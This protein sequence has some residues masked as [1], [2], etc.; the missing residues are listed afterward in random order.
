MKT[1]W[2]HLVISDLEKNESFRIDH[3]FKL[4]GEFKHEVQRC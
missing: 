4:N 3:L 2:V 1:S